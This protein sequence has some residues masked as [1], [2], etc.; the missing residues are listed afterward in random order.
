MIAIHHIIELRA[1]PAVFDDANYITLEFVP[2]GNSPELPVSL[3]LFF[4]GPL[5][6]GHLNAL[7]R[8]IN[9][10]AVKPDHKPEFKPEIDE[11]IDDE[12][13]F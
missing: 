4:E 13:P 10:I 11:E 3:T 7:C 9:S 6:P 5:E 2:G 8:A 1:I 12:I